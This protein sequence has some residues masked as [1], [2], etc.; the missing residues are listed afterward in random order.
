MCDNGK[1][2]T[3]SRFLLNVLSDPGLECKTP[4]GA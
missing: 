1:D 4:H 2:R 3:L